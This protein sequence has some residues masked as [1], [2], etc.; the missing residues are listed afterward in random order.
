MPATRYSAL[1]VATRCA[2]DDAAMPL[3]MLPCLLMMLLPRDA[4]PR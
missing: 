1:A 4:M 3:L 2:A